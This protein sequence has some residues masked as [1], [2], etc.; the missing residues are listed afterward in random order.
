MRL[1]RIATPSGPV[2]VV[3]DGTEWVSIK[4]PYAD[5]LERTGRRW[6]QD[7]VRLLAPIEPHIMVGFIGNAAPDALDRPPKGTFKSVRS[8]VGDGEAISP[9]AGVGRLIAEGEIAVVLKSTARH[10]THEEVPGVILGYTIVNDFT[11][12]DHINDEEMLIPAKHGDGYAPAGP[13]IETDLDADDARIIVR[14]D[15]V[16]KA[17]SSTSMLK[18]TVADLLV[19][20]SSAMT[21]DAGDV[22]LTGAPNTIV[23]VDAGA[24]VG[25][26]VEG[27]GTIANPI[28]EHA[29]R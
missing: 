20:L 23:P 27:I 21:L 4:S 22:V 1:A 13:W 9:A 6:P 10:L 29:V 5:V 15:G 8:I 11:S 3:D 2:H 17:D 7:A 26:T 16:V 28:V 12:F 18:R 24:T 19:Y 14:V 25:I